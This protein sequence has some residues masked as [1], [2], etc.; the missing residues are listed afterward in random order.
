MKNTRNED[1]MNAVVERLMKHFL[2]ALQCLCREKSYYS[3]VGNLAEILD[4]AKDFSELYSGKFLNVPVEGPGA[5]F[6]NN[7]DLESLVL[8]FGRERTLAFYKEN[9]APPNYFIEKYLSLQ[10]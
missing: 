6:N 2:P 9:A 3:H 4:W 10:T 5:D 1:F 8:S 7:A